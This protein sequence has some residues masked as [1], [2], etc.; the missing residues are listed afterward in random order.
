M[1]TDKIETPRG[2]IFRTKNG[3]AKLEWN[4]NF[5][6]KWQGKYDTAQMKLDNAILKDTDKYVP[7]LTGML[8]LSGRLGTIVGSGTIM[9]IAPYSKKQYYLKRKVGSSTGALRG[10]YWFE[11]SKADNKKNWVKIV[12]KEMK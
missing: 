11:R 1:A 8:K 3:T 9:Y 10:P 2:Y 7:M 5:K 4:N 6:S 12:K